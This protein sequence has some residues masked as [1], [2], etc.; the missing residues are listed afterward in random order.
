MS[1]AAIIHKNKKVEMIMSIDYEWINKGGISVQ[2]NIVQP[3]K[4]IKYWKCY[5]M[6]KPEKRFAKWKNPV[7]K[8]R[9]LY[10]PIHIEIQNTEIHGD[11]KQITLPA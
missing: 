3:L 11:R 6:N 7:T 8:V 2:W 5:N 1:I 10:D 9:I 4:G